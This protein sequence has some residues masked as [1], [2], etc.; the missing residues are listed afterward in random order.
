MKF[1]WTFIA[2]IALGGVL[3]GILAPL[4]GQMFSKLGLKSNWDET[5]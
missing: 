2:E 1:N 4:F 5:D 3:A